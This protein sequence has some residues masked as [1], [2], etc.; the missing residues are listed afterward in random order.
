MNLTKKV[1]RN[2][3]KAVGPLTKAKHGIVELGEVGAQEMRSL[4]IIRAEAGNSD[5]SGGAQF[6]LVG[7]MKNSLQAPRPDGA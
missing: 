1:Q 7:Q 5:R 3:N 4:G 6:D 2:T